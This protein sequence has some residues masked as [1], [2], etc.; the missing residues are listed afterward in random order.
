MEAP[1]TVA[2][3]LGDHRDKVSSALQINPPIKVIDQLSK[4]GW[5]RDIA[6]RTVHTVEDQDNPARLPLG[7]KVNRKK[8]AKHK[9]YIMI[10][11]VI[12]F[13]SLLVMP[14][15]IIA[16]ADIDLCIRGMIAGIVLIFLGIKNVRRYPNRDLPN[17]DIFVTSGIMGPRDPRDKY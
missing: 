4:A 5:S 7:A 15:F 3:G 2:D 6:T 11:S 16:D 9:A 17:D 12:L 13:I 1:K 8:R 10:G 14:I